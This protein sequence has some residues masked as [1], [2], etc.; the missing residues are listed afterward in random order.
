MAT[1]DCAKTQK[2]CDPSPMS[3]NPNYASLKHNPEAT[4]GRSLRMR[5]KTEEVPGPG[6]YQVPDTHVWKSN[7]G[8]TAYF[9]I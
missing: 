6:Q 1:R 5:Q 3:Y 4:I 9:F 7:N 2:V 8:N